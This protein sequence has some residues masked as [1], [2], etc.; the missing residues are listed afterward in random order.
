MIQTML[1]NQPLP[2][3]PA[4]QLASVRSGAAI[5]VTT[6][7]IATPAGTL[8]FTSS[9]GA[10]VSQPTHLFHNSPGVSSPLH[11][12]SMVY[13]VTTGAPRLPQHPLPPTSS[14]VSTCKIEPVE[15]QQPPRTVIALKKREVMMA[16]DHKLQNEIKTKEEIIVETALAKV[17]LQH[18]PEY[19]KPKDAYGVG[20]HLR[21]QQAQ[22]QEP[23]PA[24]LIIKEVV[25]PLIFP[26]S[27][28]QAPSSSSP[29]TVLPGQ[30]P[31][32]AGYL[33]EHLQA[34]RA[35][36][37]II[38]QEIKLYYLQYLKQGQ[39]EHIAL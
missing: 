24:D 17:S 29:V 6:S 2:M 15:L 23:L 19:L 36:Q 20:A 32:T 18:Q 34:F 31:S 16:K 37:D 33:P 13:T 7:T 26:P 39:P 12:T 27:S 14:A 5:V 35:Q 10:T 11:S 1:P 22:K 4:Q 21:L 30:S 25:K 8:P 3:T 28:Q 9:V 38:S